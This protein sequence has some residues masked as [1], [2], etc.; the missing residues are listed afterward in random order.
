MQASSYRVE[1]LIPHRAPMALVDEV[2]SFDREAGCAVV[3]FKARRE[4]S[5]PWA[6]IEYM[7]QAS[8]V[9]AGAADIADGHVGPP[10][11]GFLLGT[12]RLELFL[13][14]FEPGKRYVAKAKSVFA[15]SDSASFEC[16]ILD[17][18]TVVARATLNAFRP[19]DAAAFMQAQRDGPKEG[20]R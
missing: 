3:A 10:R 13:P 6:A 2:V 11:P 4:W 9:L 8:A 14:R 5:E 18:E 20:I 1:V 15:D 19:P 7:A 17:G 12:R 16:E